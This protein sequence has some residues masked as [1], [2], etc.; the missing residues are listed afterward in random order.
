MG[1][2]LVTEAGALFRGPGAGR[3][4]AWV[5]RVREGGGGDAVAAEQ[6]GPGH[7]VG[8]VAEA[9]AVRLVGRAE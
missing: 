2:E 6:T 5:R 3:E 9:K 8:R 4:S 1:S 7:E